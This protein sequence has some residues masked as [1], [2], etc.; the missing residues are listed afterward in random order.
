MSFS[1]KHSKITTKKIKISI[2][3][4]FS[5]CDLVTFTIE[6]LYEK[7]HFCTVDALELKKVAHLPPDVQGEKSHQKLIISNAIPNTQR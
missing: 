4:F 5:K 1:L 2:K 3:D 6:I 7:F